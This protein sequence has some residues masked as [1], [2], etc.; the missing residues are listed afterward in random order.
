MSLAHFLRPIDSG[1]FIGTFSNE[2]GFKTHF[3]ANEDEY[4]DLS[5]IAAIEIKTKHNVKNYL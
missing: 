3:T 1:P 4:E 5:L 2:K